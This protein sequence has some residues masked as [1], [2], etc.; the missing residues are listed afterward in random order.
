MLLL[1]VAPQLNTIN[2]QFQS[3][4]DVTSTRNTNAATPMRAADVAHVEIPHLAINSAPGRRVTRAIKRR[5]RRI[6]CYNCG[7]LPIGST[8]GKKIGRRLGRY[9]VESDDCTLQ[10]HI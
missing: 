5:R 6:Q 10:I 3:F 9:L 1:Y 8:Q 2:C 7:Y 4:S